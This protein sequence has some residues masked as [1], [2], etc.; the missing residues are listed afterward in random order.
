MA[1]ALVALAG[2]AVELLSP[3]QQQ[4]R[5][6]TL[7]HLSVR[8][9]RLG[10]ELARLPAA[11][12]TSRSLAVRRIG[13][14]LMRRD[15]DATLVGPRG[16]YLF[17]Y[18]DD[19]QRM[20]RRGTAPAI[21]LVQ[22]RVINYGYGWGLWV[23]VVTRVRTAAGPVTIAVYRSLQDAQT[24]RHALVAG[25]E[26][27]AAISLL[28]AI[29]LGIW[30]ARRLARR[31]RTLRDAALRVAR[32]GPGVDGPV[33]DHG[34]EIGDLAR[35]FATMQQRLSAQERAR[36]AFVATAS[37]ELRTPLTAL[38]MRLGLLREDL[39]AGS[40]DL[41]DAREQ[42]ALAEGQAQRLGKLAGDLL[43]LSRLDAQIPMA[44]E[45]VAL[46]PLARASVAELGGIL[47]PAV[48]LEVDTAVIVLGDAQRIAQILRIL[49]DNA[50]R[51]SPAGATV[52]VIVADAMIAVEDDGPG[53]PLAERE[54]IFERF[55]RGSS[56]DQHPGFGL[57]LAIGREL[58][59]RMGG[60]L[61]LCGA[62]PPTRFELHLRVAATSVAD[63]GAVP[64]R[65][66]TASRDR[67]PA[68]EGTRR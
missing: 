5:D 10:Q 1:V 35:A 30:F 53:I 61:T 9:E 59:R 54:L 14:G 2:P 39:S 26:R 45:P 50:R 24:A 67:A 33:D 55:R 3:L 34:D 6:R 37:H 29:C 20:V 32:H 36:Q 13:G 43:D 46:V 27:A 48:R 41:L 68:T 58:A 7:D 57:G 23:R 16:G 62:A 25:L 8:A 21:G 51:Y 38:Q 60:E 17:G 49:I 19:I 12:V 42:V 15:L 64:H 56:H 40:P 11:S 4:L 28:I 44:I 52:R 18:D 63:R 47:G 65:S 31:T 22:R 66:P